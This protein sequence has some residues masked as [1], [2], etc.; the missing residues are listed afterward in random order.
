MPAKFSECQVIEI[1]NRGASGESPESLAKSLGISRA[2]VVRI[3]T[4]AYY[5]TVGGPRQEST[6]GDPSLEEVYRMAREIRAAAPRLL[7]GESLTGHNPIPVVS[8]K[9]LSDSW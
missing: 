9:F 1:R 2:H 8:T 4:G 5:P 3:L 7:V 6:L